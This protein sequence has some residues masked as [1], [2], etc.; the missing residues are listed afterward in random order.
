M[1]D[2]GLL[3]LRLCLGATF[4]AHGLQKTFGLFEGPGI[5][6]LSKWLATLGFAPA[7]VWAY[8]L[9]LTELVGGT[10]VLLGLFTRGAAFFIFVAMVVAIAR[11]HLNKGFFAG[12]G[13]FEYPFVLACACLT[14]VITGPGKYSILKGF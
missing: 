2:L 1:I 6:G 11:V 4:V 5:A 14:L 12:G 9:A 13:G 8:V 10:F 7:T 3:V